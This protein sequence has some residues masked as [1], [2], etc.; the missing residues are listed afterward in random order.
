M[1]KLVKW[2]IGGILGSYIGIVTATIVVNVP[3][4]PVLNELPYLYSGFYL[5]LSVHRLYIKWVKNIR[6]SKENIQEPYKETWERFET[7]E[8][9]VFYTLKHKLRSFLL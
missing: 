8:K 4:V 1:E 5:P 3:K 9:V 6:P 7:T 2:H